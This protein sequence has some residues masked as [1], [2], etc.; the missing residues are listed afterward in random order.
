MNDL[1]KILIVPCIILALLLGYVT[2]RPQEKW[3]SDLTSLSAVGTYAA[4]SA[5][6][7]FQHGGRLNCLLTLKYSPRE[8]RSRRM[9]RI[10]EAR[11]HRPGRFLII[12]LPNLF[13]ELLS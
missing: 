7:L 4:S 8:C 12:L 11:A 13:L 3:Y 6:G 9:S 10:A 5:R 1:I 2:W